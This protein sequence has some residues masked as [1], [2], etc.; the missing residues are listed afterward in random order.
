MPLSQSCRWCQT[1]F[2]ISEE[3][4][5]FYDKVSPVFDGK[6]Y[7]V[8]SPTL[9]P[10]C[11]KQ[12]RL[13]FRNERQ[14]Y[15]R[16]CDLCH[17]DIVSMYSAEKKQPVYCPE[18]WNSDAWDTPSPVH[19]MDFDIPFFSLFQGLFQQVPIPAL[20]TQNN[21]NS[22]YINLAGWNK[23]C[24]LIFNSPHN[25]DCYYARGIANSKNSMDMYFGAK[26]ERCYEGINIHNCYNTSFSQNCYQCQDSF[27]LLNCT[28][29]SY[30]FGC[31]NLKHKKFHIFNQPYSEQEYKKRIQEMTFSYRDLQNYKQQFADLIASSLHREN[32]NMNTEN[33]TG[34]YLANCKNCHDSFEVTSGEDCKFCDSIKLCKDIYDAFGHCV[35]SELQYEVLATGRSQKMSFCFNNDG[36]HD[37]SYSAFCNNSSYLFGC[38]GIRNKSYCIFNKQYTKE[39]YETLLPKIIEHMQ[40]TG[41]WGEFFPPS[42]SPF[43][44]NETVAQEYFPLS[45]EEAL[46]KDFHW[47]DYE[48]PKP[49]VKK[50]IPASKLPDTIK[51]I[52]DDILNW[53]IECEVTRKPFKII[54]QELLFYRE[55]NLPVPRRH[56]DQRHK[57]R[58]KLRNPRKLWQRECMKCGRKIQTTYA[59]DRP[60]TVYCEACYLQEVY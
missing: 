50:I 22:D 10:D 35:N 45:K 12:R 41:E 54:K 4:S 32:Q 30:C 33:C 20:F 11:R 55:H 42:L 15:N 36:C 44:Y 47:S 19:K 43:G 58:I 56:P 52:P 57:D 2:E 46:Q 31:T 29:C 51:D 27:F 8:S 34:D 49:D 14:L 1:G 40:K 48:S 7:P 38:V 37:V 59:P 28:S 24:Y 3:D 60:E 6:K 21:E 26:N 13:S 17:T 25:E 5:V 53:A 23:N 18:C 39:E 16:Q 9:C